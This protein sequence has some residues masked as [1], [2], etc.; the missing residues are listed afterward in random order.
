MNQRILFK[1]WAPDEP[2]LQAPNL[3]VATGVVPYADH[4]RPFKQLTQY[5]GNNTAGAMSTTVRG[6][7]VG[8]AYADDRVYAGAL[9]RIYSADASG[10]MV[11]RS[12]TLTSISNDWDFAQYDNLMIA[13]SWENP[14]LA[15]TVGAATNFATLASSGTAPPAF[16]IGVIGQFVMVGNLNES[17]GRRPYTVRWCGIDQPNSWP[18][19]NS[20][21]A[22]AQQSGEQDLN[23]QYGEILK[24]V[25]GDQ[26]GIIMQRGAL[27]RVTYVGGSTVFQFDTYEVSH[28][29]EERSAAI[30]VGGMVYYKSPFGFRV[31]DGVTSQPIGI[32]KVDKQFAADRLAGGASINRAGFD[33][34][35]R[36]VLWC[37][38]GPTSAS[39]IIYHYNIDNQRWAKNAATLYA[40][41]NTYDSSSDGLFAFNSQL[42]LAYFNGNSA[43]ATLETGEFGI[44]G[45]FSR[46]KG[47]TPLVTGAAVESLSVVPY[48]RNTLIDAAS[49]AGTISVSSRTGSAPVNV[50][51]RYHRARVTISASSTFDKAWGVDVDIVPSGQV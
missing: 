48:S 6:M 26:F 11:A 18:T 50:E 27:T 8:Y 29:L 51:G 32:G 31:T 16:C 10:T 35:S 14:P 24:I 23:A 38:G 15:H 7:A 28:G 33:P 3:T 36:C 43:A 45:R 49:A 30:K 21:T 20:A 37:F 1:E 41:T 2:D 9:D 12:A 40:I 47:V 25:R 22:I 4:Y 34:N 13:T 44:D 5:Y 19:P 46:V 39:D 17:S 42:R